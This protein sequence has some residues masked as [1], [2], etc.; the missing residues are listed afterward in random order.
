MTD[1]RVPE[2][3]TFEWQQSVIS[4]LADPPAVPVRGD[5]YIVIAI[6]TGDWVGHENS[7]A[8]CSNSTGPVWTYIV[9]TE[10]YVAWDEASNGFLYF[11]GTSWLLY[12]TG[13]TSTY[14]VY[15]NASGQVQGTSK[16][17]FNGT[18]FSLAIGSSLRS[19]GVLV[20]A[21]ASGS[22]FQLTSDG[23]A[24]GDSA[25]DLQTVRTA[26]TQVASGSRAAILSGYENT[27]TA[28]SST[29]VSGRQN[30]VIPGSTYETYSCIIGGYQNQAQGFACSVCGGI[31]NT[32]LLAAG[33]QASSIVGGQNNTVTGSYDSICGGYQNSVAYNYNT[34]CGGRENVIPNDAT[35]RNTICGGHQNSIVLASTSNGYNAIGGGRTNTLQGQ[36]CAILGG[37][38]N[39]IALAAGVLYA[40]IVGGRSNTVG[41]SYGTICG[42][43]LNTIVAGTNGYT[44]IVGGYSNTTVAGSTYN[45]SNVI[46]GYDN[47]VQGSYSVVA[48]GRENDIAVAAG[49]IA[50]VISGGYQHDLSGNYA[51][52]PGG[53]ENVASGDNSIATGFNSSATRYGQHA[54]AAGKIVTIG[55]AETSVFVVRNQTSDA[56]ETELFLDGQG[57][58][59]SIPANTSWTYR[60][61][62]IG[63]CTSGTPSVPV[64]GAD[65]WGVID[66]D[67]SNNTTLVH[68]VDA[69]SEVAAQHTVTANDTYEAL[70]ISVTGEALCYFS[71]VVR[72]E[73]AEVTG[74]GTA[75]QGAVS[76][77]PD[78]PV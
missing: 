54:H 56:T 57:L 42:G 27:V 7:I 77:N 65:G 39:S 18:D 62:L 46:G 5:R 53:R 10:G 30:S 32:I 66:R 72:I 13:L 61:S 28:G 29:V 37:L 55:D 1:F 26:V 24:R 17:T 78:N 33:V 14:M 20:C 35:G 60:Y 34:V 73:L 71:W 44:T 45:G 2:L 69:Q 11:N 49:T 74:T 6:A 47:S 25:V 40:A 58:R 48:G 59:L 64:Y 41:V 21:P 31:G 15:A 4:Q 51:T 22:A 43:Y 50:G 23:N 12:W 9:P 68:N 75:Q 52:I 16:L 38:S 63:R 70:V 3:S 19:A 8:W 76:G 67:G 36:Y